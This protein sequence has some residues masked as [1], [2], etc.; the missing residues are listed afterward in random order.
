MKFEQYLQKRELEII[1]IFENNKVAEIYAYGETVKSD[2]NL[3][4]SDINLFVELNIEDHIER[5]DHYHTLWEELEAF[6]LRKINL[7][8]EDT[9]RNPIVKMLIERDKRLVYVNCTN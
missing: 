4:K 3:K 8:C 7:I 1:P 5:R 6:F 9:I 2:F